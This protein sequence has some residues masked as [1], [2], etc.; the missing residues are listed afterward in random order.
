MAEY[1]AQ[2]AIEAQNTSARTRT[3]TLRM[4]IPGLLT[5]NQLV[6]SGKGETRKT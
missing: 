2:C 1:T 6:L 3:S 5:L 4:R